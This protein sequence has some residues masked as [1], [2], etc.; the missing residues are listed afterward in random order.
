MNATAMDADG[1]VRRSQLD[2]QPMWRIVLAQFLEHRAAVAGVVVIAMFLLVALLAPVI[3]VVTGLDPDR[4]NVLARYQPLFSWESA[5]TAER[6]LQVERFL[7]SG[8]RSALAD[9]LRG[10]GLVAPG[11]EAGEVLYETVREHEPQALLAL[12]REAAPPAAEATR[13]QLGEFEQGFGVDRAAVTGQPGIDALAVPFAQPPKGVHEDFSLFKLYKILFPVYR[14][15]L[16]SIKRIFI[17]F[18]YFRSPLSLEDTSKQTKRDYKQ[19]PNR[20]ILV[21]L[22]VDVSSVF[23]ITVI[24]NIIHHSFS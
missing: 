4:Q 7:R 5:S 12:L 2:A 15:D 16:T 19:S 9:Y 20:Y 17:V 18:A 10:L 11:I 1:T 14:Y 23:D 24:S 22:Q 6:E 13:S 8:D 3:S 21:Y